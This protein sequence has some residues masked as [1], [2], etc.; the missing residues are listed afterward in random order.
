MHKL[1]NEY[2]LDTYEAALSYVRNT[3]PV[4]AT[5]SITASG[6]CTCQNSKCSK[7]GKHPATRHG[8]KDA[9]RDPKE[10]ADCFKNTPFN[11][12]IATGKESGLFV[13]D[14]DKKSGGYESLEKLGPLP[15]TLTVNTGGGG[16][17]LYYK[18]PPGIT[19]GISAGELAAG[20]DTRGEGGYVIAPP[21]KHISGGVYSWENPDAEIADIPSHLLEAILALDKKPKQPRSKDKEVDATIAEGSRNDTLASIAG[22]FLRKGLTEDALCNVLK[23]VNQEQCFPPLPEE[24]VEILSKGMIAR[25]GKHSQE[26]FMDLTQYTDTD[27]GNAQCFVERHGYGIRY[28]HTR[29]QWLIWTGKFWKPDMSGEITRLAIET[30]ENIHFSDFQFILAEG[31][32]SKAQKEYK[33]HIKNSKQNAKLK[34]MLEIACNLEAVVILEEE[35]DSNKWL[36]NLDNGTLDLNGCELKAHRKE[37]YITKILPHTYDKNAKCPVF[38]KFLNEITVG[39]K[40]KATYLQQITGYSLTGETK[41]HAAFFLIGDGANGKSTYISTMHFLLR[42]YAASTSMATFAKHKSDRIRSDI[43]GLAGTRFVSILEWN[44]EDHL[45]EGM[46]K[47]VTG[48]DIVKERLLYKEFFEFKPEFKLFF[49][50]ND[51]PSIKGHG[52][53]VWRR[54]KVIPFNAFFPPEKQDKDLT[55]KLE[56]EISGILN[57]AIEGLKSWQLWGLQVPEE[58]SQATEDYLANMDTIGA[59]IRQECVLGDSH[60]I[61]RAE[62]HRLYELWCGESGHQSLSR[63]NLVKMLSKRF[64]T[65]K[66]NGLYYY[67]G[68]DFYHDPKAPF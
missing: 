8:F 53:G 20:L 58:V 18:Y 68:I 32:P 41:E 13:L 43:A 29:K 31:D 30:V 22:T 5:H 25:Y 1:L 11:V 65:R 64:Q 46:F 47:R 67:V 51:L 28:C 19:I 42:A 34:A 3:W 60:S 63:F 17:H 55:S 35:L 33:K 6:E 4:F 24:E 59:F 38:D 37:D 54:I 2:P 52:E 9:T 14:V 26:N 49:A 27:L 16:K 56:L 40:G 23:V 66:R 50:L 39:N 7:Q 36:L 62:L 48:G 57:W 10:I 12:A 15:E 21:S 61:E 45:D 44:E